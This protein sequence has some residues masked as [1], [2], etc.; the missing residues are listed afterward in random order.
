MMG[1]SQYLINIF[2]CFRKKGLLFTCLKI[3]TEILWAS[4]ANIDHNAYNTCREFSWFFPSP[5]KQMPIQMTLTCHPST[6][7]CNVR[8][9]MHGFQTEN[10]EVLGATVPSLVAQRPC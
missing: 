10:T 8:P 9:W 3:G 7:H 6:R 4:D 5:F 2:I 1:D